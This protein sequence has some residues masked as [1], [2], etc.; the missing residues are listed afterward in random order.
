MKFILTNENGVY[1]DSFVGS[2]SAAIKFFK[3]KWQTAKC[4]VENAD[5]CEVVK[6]FRK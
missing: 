3:A 4:R 1:L 6:R 2:K 5:T